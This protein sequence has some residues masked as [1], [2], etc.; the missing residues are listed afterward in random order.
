MSGF[1]IGTQ[2]FAP[3]GFDS[4]K[5]ETTYYLLKSSSENG[6]V[7]LVEFEIK[8]AHLMEY[9]S[10]TRPK[11]M[12]TPFPL[13]KIAA[14]SRE[15]F[16]TGLRN[17]KIIRCAVQT[18]MPPWLHGLEG[19][20][21]DFHEQ[22]RKKPSKSH[23]ARINDRIAAIEALVNDA[24]RV[25]GAPNPDRVINAHARQCNPVKNEPRVRLWFYTYLVFGRNK[26]ALHYPIQKIGVWSRENN[27]TL[28]KLGRP[29]KN[30]GHGSG[31]NVT[32]Q[33]KE[34][35][36]KGWRRYAKL[37]VR[38]TTIHRKSL[39]NIFGCSVRTVERGVSK[40]KEFWHHDGN[41]FPS[42]RQFC[43]HLLK[44]YGREK[45][46]IALYGYVRYR[47]KEQL[48]KGAFTSN[49]WNLMQSVE[50]DAFVR[51]QISSGVLHGSP[52][53]SIHVVRIRDVAS[54]LITGIGFSM[55][56]ETAASYR[57]ALFC[58]AIEKVKFCSLLGYK[59][60]E[61]DWPSIGAAPREIQ[62]RGAGST[63]GAFSQT[64]EFRPVTKQSPPSYAGQSKATIESTNPKKPKNSEAPSYQ[65][66]SLTPFQIVKAEIQDVLDL[67]DS[68]NVRSRVPPELAHEIPRATPKHLW[69]LLDNLGRNDGIAM[70]FEDAVRAYLTPFQAKLK[71]NIVSLL[72][73]KYRS[74]ELDEVVKFRKM[75]GTQTLNIKVYVLDAC[76]QFIWI[77]IKGQMLELAVQFDIPVSE[78][79][80]NMSIAECEEYFAYIQSQDSMQKEH[81]QAT[82]AEGSERFQE[83]QGYDREAVS[84]ING[85]ANRKTLATLAEGEA[86]KKIFQTKLRVR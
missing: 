51:G 23:L 73:R 11:R 61:G 31:Y 40:S 21:L 78:T 48:T 7:L 56:G 30:K 70:Q 8:P 24:D 41:P 20:N 18:N 6:R 83:S 55:G 14:L 38:L 69:N 29:D 17:G 10:K 2:L 12:V 63:I 16:E 45:M 79:V 42:F 36:V 85:R 15:R 27:P 4:L 34:L 32:S 39:T 74:T 54:G 28:T 1:A 68:I 64:D 58:Q 26:N 43:Y 84:R 44:E 77:E 67:N 81:R 65:K 35:I 49:T 22:N 59:I 62:D 72:G 57:M 5:H 25:L 33:V 52:M 66:T 9:K 86:T 3:T 47:S 53:P 13:P 37:G 71:G 75:V 76:L 60:K 50:R 19:V 82:I 46:Q 80:R